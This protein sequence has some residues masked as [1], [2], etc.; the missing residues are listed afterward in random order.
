MKKKKNIYKIFIVI[1]LL[2]LGVYGYWQTR[3]N[4]IKSVVIA[5]QQIAVQAV[6]SPDDLAKGL[7]GAA[8]LPWD[9]GM[10]FLFP[11]QGNYKFWM[12][13]ML[14]P[15]DIIWLRGNMVVAISREVLPPAD[16]N[17]QTDLP[18]YS[19][20]EPIDSVLELRSGFAD[21]YGVQVGDSVVIK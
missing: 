21:R 8:D 14:I 15:L 17:H 18:L 7:A 13:D 12:K 2:A 5:G 16:L 10:L 4:T 6:S 9:K 1:V 20:R 11:R 3:V 19:S